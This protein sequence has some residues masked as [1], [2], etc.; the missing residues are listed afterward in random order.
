MQVTMQKNYFEA[1]EIAYLDVNIDNSACG[2]NC[3]LI[4]SQ[5]SKIQAQYFN[6]NN[7]YK[8]KRTHRE[9]TTFL[10]GPGES[11]RVVVQFKIAPKRLSAPR[12][13]YLGK[14]AAYYHYVN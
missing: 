4:I 2:D 9:E 10:C 8:V 1:G 7:L 6:N 11:K 3:S 12:A 13:K 5:R 14:Q